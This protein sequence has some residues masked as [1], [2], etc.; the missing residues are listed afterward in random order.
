MALA[1]SAS[2]QVRSKPRAASGRTP[3]LDSPRPLGHPLRDPGLDRRRV[4]LDRPSR[5]IRGFAHAAPRRF[6]STTTAIP[7]WYVAN[8][9]VYFRSFDSDEQLWCDHLEYNTDDEKGKFYDVEGETMPRI[10]AKPGMLMAKARFILKE[11]GPNA[12]ARST[13]STTAG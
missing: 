7:A 6:R 1:I 11:N 3:G 9:H 8:G 4:R 2:A 13:F 12:W 5:R 10:I